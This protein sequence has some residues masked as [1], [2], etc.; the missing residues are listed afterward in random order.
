MSE[1]RCDDWHI[2]DGGKVINMMEKWREKHVFE[3]GDKIDQNQQNDLHEVL[4]GKERDLVL[5]AQLGKSLLEKNEELN[6]KNKLIAKECLMKLQVIY[7]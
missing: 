5:A 7:G 1:K 3:M 6:K 4:E 2:G